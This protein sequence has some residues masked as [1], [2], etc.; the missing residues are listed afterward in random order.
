MERNGCI[1]ETLGEQ[2]NRRDLDRLISDIVPCPEAQSE[3]LVT[4]T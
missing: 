1:L 4:C 2:I 3:I